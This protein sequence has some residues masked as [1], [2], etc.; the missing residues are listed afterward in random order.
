VL[1]TGAG[2]GVGR[3][4]VDVARSMGARVIGVASSE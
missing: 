2:G 4:C 3:A 1:V